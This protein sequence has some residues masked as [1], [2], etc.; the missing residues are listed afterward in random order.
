MCRA[1][2]RG[3]EGKKQQVANVQSLRCGASG[4]LVPREVFR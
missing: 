1:S 3:G 2:E 4:G